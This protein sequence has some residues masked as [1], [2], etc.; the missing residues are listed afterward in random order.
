MFAG[1]VP[2]LAL[3]TREHMSRNSATP[4]PGLLLPCVRCSHSALAASPAGQP[5]VDYLAT[6]A[7]HTHC[8][9]RHAVERTC[10][11]RRHAYICQLVDTPRRE[12]VLGVAVPELAKDAVAPLTARQ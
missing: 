3:T 12:L 9:H 6:A 11:H 7:C 4:S 5:N 2:P 10:R 8:T 1:R